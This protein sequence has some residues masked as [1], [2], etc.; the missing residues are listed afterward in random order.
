MSGNRLLI[1]DDDLDVSTFFRDVAESLGYEVR[2]LNDAAYF[3]KTVADI[4]PD[5]ILLDLQLPK[6]DGIELLRGLA[7]AK[8]RSRIFIASGLET[9]ILKTAE[10]LGKSLGLSIAGSFCKP[11]ELKALKAL[12]QAHRHEERVLSV[13]DLRY[14]ID[15]GQLVVHY[16]P[17]ATHKG[18]GRWIVDGVEALVRWQHEE[19]GLIYPNE[20]LPLAEESGLIVGLTDYVFRAAM[21]Q[22]RVWF[23]Q[24]IYFELG[25]NLSANFLADLEFPDRLVALIREKGLD[26]GMLTLELTETSSMHDPDLALAILARLRVQRVKLCLD[27]FGVGQA[28]LTHLYKMPFNEVKLDNAFIRDMQASEEARHTVEGLIFLIQKLNMHAC[29]EGVEDESTFQFLQSIGC[30]QIQGHY[31]GP[32]LPAR[33]LIRVATNWNAR[34]PETGQSETA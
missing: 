26:P 34:Y 21:D 16:L 24:G 31:I 14:A 32:A 30:D 8:C 29:A 5:L 17:K 28:S 15:A 3:A 6:H 27:D 25:L 12:L 33:E 2:V 9:R 19:H 18:Q 7:E 13:D 10:Q 11:I 1:M 23:S 4:E 20:F 22:A